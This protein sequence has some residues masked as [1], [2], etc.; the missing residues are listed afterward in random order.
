MP[1]SDSYRSVAHR[2][3]VKSINAALAR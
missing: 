1:E 2:S 3:T